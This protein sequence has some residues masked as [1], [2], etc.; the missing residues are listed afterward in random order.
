MNNQK[1]IELDA[2][3]TDQTG[4]VLYVGVAPTRKLL[5]ITAVDYYNPQLAPTD[6][7]QGYQ[8]PPEKSRITKIGSFLIEQDGKLIFPNSVLLAS[9][10]VL[11]YDKK[12]GLVNISTESPLQ[13]VDGQHRLAGLKYAI[14]N[15]GHAVFENFNIPFVIMEISDKLTE[16]TQFRVINSTAKSVRT[17][18]V[19]MIL[20]ATYADTKKIE[21]PYKDQWKIVVSNVV[22][23]LAKDSNSPWHDIIILPGEISSR[24]TSKDKIIR[25]TSIITSLKPVYNWLHDTIYDHKMKTLEQ[26]QE[27]LYEVVSSFWIALKSTVPVAFV[28]PN[29]YVIQKTPGLFSLHKLLKLLLSDMYRGRRDFTVDNFVEFLKDNPE[30]T[31]ADFWASDSKRASVYGSMKGFDELYEI[32]SDHYRS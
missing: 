1:K 32:I 9:R 16:M 30:L 21:I 27:H 25:A 28:Y 8:R 2:I 14:E 31:D 24:S 4:T 7:K 18:L 17:D 29:K 12:Q 19:N 10:K 5:D 23:R 20:S 15:K 11:E 22:D 13:I 3:K 26:E 6:K